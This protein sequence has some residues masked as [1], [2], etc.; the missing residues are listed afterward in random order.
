M[1][2]R[3]KPTTHVG[4]EHIEVKQSINSAV[5]LQL[6][7]HILTETTGASIDSFD[8]AGVSLIKKLQ[9]FLSVSL[10]ESDVIGHT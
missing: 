5:P 8:F 6:S 10:H 9:N 7:R 3:K 2:P 1:L 4:L